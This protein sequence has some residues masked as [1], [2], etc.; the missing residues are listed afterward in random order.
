MKRKIKQAVLD[1]A[2]SLGMLS[3][4][5]RIGAGA[6]QSI[7][8]VVH[9]RVGYAQDH[10]HLNPALINSTPEQLDYQFRMI[11]RHY[12]P[13]S[14]ED[15]LEAIAG[16]RRLPEQAVLV[17][18]DDGYRDFKDVIWPTARRHGIRPVLFVPTGFVERGGFWWDRIY[19]ALRQADQPSV[20]TPVGALNIRT[21]AEKRL[22]VRQIDAYIKRTKPFTDAVKMVDEICR[23]LRHDA[24]AEDHS[25]LNWD[26]L[27]QLAREGATLAPHTHNHPALGNIPVEEARREMAESQRLL[28]QEI[29]SVLPVFAYPYGSPPTLSSAVGDTARELG[30]VLAFTMALGRANLERDDRLWL[31]RL[32][33]A[34]SYSTGQT[35][36]QL[37]PVYDRVRRWQLARRMS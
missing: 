2:E 23:S 8:V 4:A 9:H 13:V 11:A 12:R 15:V 21:A 24:P 36:A 33:A 7:Y 3:I 1:T 29:G 32:P 34:V 5:Q 17:T 6:G 16:G 20:P 37:T 10:P 18:V 28:A 31:P 30:L 35:R 22:A 26:E 19:N 27:R 25:T 14:A